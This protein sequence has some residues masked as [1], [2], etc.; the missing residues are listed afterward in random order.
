MGTSCVK[1]V[2][3]PYRMPTNLHSAPN[4][5]QCVSR[6]EGETGYYYF[7]NVARQCVNM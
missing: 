2:E 4:V 7:C 3:V 5:M 1:F 6:E